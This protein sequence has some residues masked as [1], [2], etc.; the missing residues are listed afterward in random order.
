MSLESK[1]FDIVSSKDSEPFNITWIST[2]SLSS[3]YYLIGLDGIIMAYVLSNFESL[4]ATK[5]L[6]IT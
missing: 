6:L 5:L 2:G 3:T 4:L 1:E